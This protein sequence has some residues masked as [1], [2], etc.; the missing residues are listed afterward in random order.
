MSQAVVPS[1]PV[2]PSSGP[3]QATSAPAGSPRLPTLSVRKAPWWLVIVESSYL[4]ALL[5]AAFFY[6]RSGSFRSL[7]PDPIGTIPLSVAWWGALGAVTIG[8]YGIFTHQDSWDHS[9]DYWHYA[10]PLTGAVLGVVSYAIF[11][12]VIQATGT[13]PN[14]K[15]ALAYDLA[16]FLVG[17]NE[18]TF[19][20]LIKRAISSLFGSGNSGSGAAPGKETAQVSQEPSGPPANPPS[21]QLSA[22]EAGSLY[23]WYVK[24][25]EAKHT[26]Q[27]A[28]VFPDGTVV[29]APTAT[30]AL[31]RAVADVGRGSTVFAVGKRT[32][33][34]WR[35]PLR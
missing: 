18:K 14:S 23:D 12:V 16:A 3:P 33:G 1:N 6:A 5:L 24:P 2:T 9:Y 20:S 34:T 7:F 15:G 32:V 28:A 17:Y 13:T 30:E 27:Y 21:G 4:V 22:D 26:G 19:Q 31:K 25:L 29:L 35:L 10:R 11:V 8:M